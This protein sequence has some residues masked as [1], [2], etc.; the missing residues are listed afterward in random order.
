[1]KKLI[2]LLV[3]IVLHSSSSF[4]QFDK[5]SFQVGVGLAQPM[6][7]LKGESP[8]SYANSWTG[9]WLNYNTS[10]PHLDSTILY[11]ILLVDSGF[12]KENYASKTGFSI[13]GSLKI[14]FDK[15]N[16]FRGLVSVSYSNFNSFE[17]DKSGNMPFLLNNGY[18]ISPITYS[19]SFNI[20]G[21]GL[22]VEVA[23][24]SFTNIFT[25]FI[26]GSFNFNFLSAELT[27]SFGRDSMKAS[28]GSEFRIGAN[29]N[30]G[31]EFKGI[32]GVDLIVGLKYD[33]GNLL[34]KTTRSSIN[35]YLDW[36]KTNMSLNDGEG[37]YYTS[38]TNPVGGGQGAKL[39]H[40]NDKQINWWTVYLGV[41]IYPNILSKPE[42]K[43]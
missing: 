40:T 15:Y 7:D 8:F 24:T 27:R 23:P 21:I 19:S 5:I 42:P 18:T 41:N 22:G 10:P 2:I 20:F 36:G 12:V 29:L 43:K 16:T 33:F 28:F 38:L 6:N 14:N 31:L 34:L 4:A 17:G 11:N 3:L 13:F 25:P 30:A 9:Y 39:T 1:M 37:Y 26:G 32:R 35:D